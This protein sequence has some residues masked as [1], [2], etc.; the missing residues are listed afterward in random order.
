[1]SDY[2][3]LGP[4]PAGEEC[5]QLGDTYDAVAAKRERKAYINQLERMFGPQMETGIYF[6]SKGFPHDFGTYYEVCVIYNE[7]DDEQT[8]AAFHVE[9]NLPESWDDQAVLELK[10]G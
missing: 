2:L 4:T 8:E 1:M 7:N 9:N 6:K 3:E 10:N 5:Q